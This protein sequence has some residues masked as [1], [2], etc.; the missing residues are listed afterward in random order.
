MQLTKKII[1]PLTIIATSSSPTILHAGSAD[2]IKYA[3]MHYEESDDRI[4]IDYTLLDIKKN[5]GTDYTLDVSLSYDAISG[6]T[7][8][9]DS[10]S[11]GSSL[12]TSDT[13]SGA[14][15][16]VNEAEEYQCKDTRSDDII[17][18]GKSDSEDFVYRNVYIDDIRRAVTASLTTRTLSRDEITYGLAYS[19][20]TD[21][22]SYEGSLGY[23]YNL[24]NSKNRSI[25]LGASYQANDAYHYRT[26]IWKNFN[27]VNA[28][29]G[30]TQVF[31]KYSTG[32]INVFAI[33]Q[34]GEL[35]NP[36]QTII[37]AFDVSLTD[38][39]EIKYYRATEKRP[40]SRK[41][42]GMTIFTSSKLLPNTALHGYYRYY[43]DDWGVVSHTA[44]AN[45][46]IDFASSWT[47]IPLLRTYRQS[48]SVFYKAYDAKDFTFN[49]TDFGS[50]DER[51]GGFGTVTYS[52]GLEKKL[53][54][55][56]KSKVHVAYQKQTI[57]LEMTWF[58][59]GV[60]YEF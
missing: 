47:F 58:H 51:L 5:F 15:A 21:F 29:A 17:G 32:Q 11:G 24:D 45:A 57:G 8:V 59:L 27:I 37:R 4:D 46:Y 40:N 34:S 42:M 36:Y 6:G 12:A 2:A 25:S 9:W 30:L 20:E 14:S 54:R 48:D 13:V 53:M 38:S 50:S 39:P 28:Q 33:K 18:D 26:N 49:E 41:A 55:N 44:T 60:N 16:C 23:M 19:K 1:L 31:T 10:I 52:L 56:L 35:S 43:S 7:P 22:E 3:N